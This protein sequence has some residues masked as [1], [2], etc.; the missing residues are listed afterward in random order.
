MELVGAE[1]PPIPYMLGEGVN[2]LTLR[3]QFYANECNST[4]TSGTRGIYP[5]C[6][7]DVD[8]RGHR[9]R[10][11][12]PVT[13]LPR[14]SWSSDNNL[15]EIYHGS[16][17]TPLTD[18]YDDRRPLTTLLLKIITVVCLQPLKDFHDYRRPL[19]TLNSKLLW[20]YA[21]NL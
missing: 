15:F 16:T 9:L 2:Y 18:F 13:N 7:I 12:S 17:F 19:T 20:W 1:P 6:Y 8:E 3:V 11:E 5:H 10:A 4:I 21:Y 14:A